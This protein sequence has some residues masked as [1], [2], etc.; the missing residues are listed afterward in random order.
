MI[1]DNNARYVQTLISGLL[2]T[3]SACGGTGG[4]A[5]SDPSGRITFELPA[6]WTEEAGSNAT[7][8]S[9]PG[10]PGVQVQVNTVDDN[11]RVTLAQRRD[12]WLDFH[13]KNGATIHLDREWLAG[14]LPGLEYAHS[15]QGV[16]G[17]MT[18]HHILLSGDGYVVATYLQASPSDY[19]EILPV[20][21]QIVESVRPARSD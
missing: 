8:F 4:N 1:E 14:N 5:M 12:S 16:R 3:L 11:G 15:A 17:D 20:Y 13:R 21:R 6:G 2:L 7:R 10:S 18:W 9:P 19:D